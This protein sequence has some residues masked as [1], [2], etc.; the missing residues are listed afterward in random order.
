MG[1]DVEVKTYVFAYYTG[2]QCSDVQPERRLVPRRCPVH[3]TRGRVIQEVETD[4]DV[5]CGHRL[6]EEVMK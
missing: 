5:E 1:A 2:C 6:R 3:E 4:H